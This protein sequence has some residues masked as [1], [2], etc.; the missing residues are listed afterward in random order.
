MIKEEL[1]KLRTLHATPKMLQMAKAD[2]IAPRPYC[3]WKGRTYT[4]N[5]YEWGLFLRCQQLNGYLKVAIFLPEMMRCGSNMPAFEIFI[6]KAGSQFITW[7]AREQKWSE[8]MIDNLPIRIPTGGKVWINPEG[9]QSIKKYLKTEAAGYEGIVE[10]QRKVRAENLEKRYKRETDPWDRELQL[11]PALPKDWEKWLCRVAIPEHFIFYDYVKT[12]ATEGRCTCCGQTVP[13]TKPTHNKKAKC[14]RCGA[15]ATYKSKGKLKYLHT[16]H[17]FAYLLQRTAEGVVCREFRVQLGFR[18]DQ[19]WKTNVHDHELRRAFF[20]KEGKQVSAYYYDWYRNREMR[21]CKGNACGTSWRNTHKGAVYGSTIPDLAKKELRFTGLREYL[22]THPKVDAEWYLAIWNRCP[23]V[24]QLIKADL[25]ELVEDC[26]EN[27][28]LLREIWNEAAQGSLA[29]KMRLD[30]Q[31]LKRL[32]DN[33][34]G[35]HH[36]HWLRKEKIDD[37]QIPDEAICWFAENHIGPA[38]LSFIK[39]RMTELQVYNYLRKQMELASMKCGEIL[40]TW[41]DYLN[42]AKK[43][44]L[45][46][47]DPYIYRPGKLKQRHDE[48]VIKSMMEDMKAAARK[49]EQEYPKVAGI[50]REIKDVYSFSGEKYTVI[51]PESIL[52]IMVEGKALNHCVG[53]STRYLERIERRESYVMFLRKNTALQQSYYTLEVEPGGTVRQKRTQNDRQHPDIEDAKKFLR[54]WQKEISKRLTEE[55]RKLAEKSKE[56]RLAG[57][58]QMRRDRVLI[59]TGDLYG[60]P[61]VDVLMAD[62]M[63][64]EEVKTA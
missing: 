13:L 47:Q 24:E 55:D 3:S 27:P 44:K 51:V 59:R 57:F 21:F 43:N 15:E 58:E 46:V 26:L 16:G 56:L 4:S 22:K 53:T 54:Q 23:Q 60:K 1:K 20:N 18:R 39:D 48:L 41:K 28:S 52:D 50:L 14:P 37:K 42:M 32:R 8:A 25:P 64:N 2:K 63:E 6:N 29:K 19:G 17:Y 35:I 36:W 7:N 34:G 40:I 12:G 11:T 9:K 10:Y 5:T 38:T 33:C 62:L 30:E 61:L 49:T 31:R 45:D